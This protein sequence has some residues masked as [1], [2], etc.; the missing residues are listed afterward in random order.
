MQ[1]Q[2]ISV[3]RVDQVEDRGMDEAACEN[4]FSRPNT[5]SKVIDCAEIALDL[6][7]G[8]LSVLNRLFIVKRLRLV[9]KT[10]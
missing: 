9:I 7:L 3:G 10:F 2:G 6:S 1:C 8:R 5:P 4:H